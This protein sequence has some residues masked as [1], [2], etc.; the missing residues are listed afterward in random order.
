MS[1]NH[2]F[3]V[4]ETTKQVLIVLGFFTTVAVVTYFIFSS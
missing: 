2:D 3:H 4:S 1:T